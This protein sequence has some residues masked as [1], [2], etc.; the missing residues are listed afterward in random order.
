MSASLAIQKAVR[1][2]LLDTPAVML[3]VAATSIFDRNSRPEKFPCVIIGDGQ[4]VNEGTTLTRSHVRVFSDLHVWTDDDSL[5]DVKVITGAVE[6]S[7][8]AKLTVE[9]FHVV[10]WSIRGARFMRDPGSIGHA[11]LTVEALVNE[12]IV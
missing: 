7:L 1:A 9:G 2:R 12:R 6:K 3:L 5:V 10:D 8:T 4:T 11:V